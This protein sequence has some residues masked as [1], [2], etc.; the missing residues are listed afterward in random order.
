MSETL[1]TGR[2]VDDGPP[3]LRGPGTWSV[4]W[5]GVRTLTVLELRQ[6]IRSARWVIVVGFWALTVGAL[7]SLIRWAAMTSQTERDSAGALMYGTVLLLVLSLAS[8]VSPALSATSV[9]GDRS[10]GVLAIM[11]STLLSPAE[12]ALGKLLAAWTSALV[13]FAVT[14]PFLF[15]AFLEGG[16]SGGRFVI[17]TV[18]TAFTLLVVCAVGLMF[19]ALTARTSTSAA[20]TYLTVAFLGVGLPLV[21]VLGLAIVRSDDTFRQ[22]Y[23]AYGSDE[24]QLELVTESRA[25]TEKTWWLL[26]PSPYVIVSD[27]APAR[28][29]LGD[30]LSI[31]RSAVREA[32]LGPP[33]DEDY[34]SESRDEDRA[35]ERDAQPAVWPLGVAVDGLVLVGSVVVTVRRLRSP[36]RALPRG[37]RVA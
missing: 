7:S 37:S 6:R 25:H 15:W 35:A 5:G 18:L 34:C 30:P 12:L 24:C 3:L 11:Q 14:L 28:H 32:R 36:S 23:R 2:P 22:Q 19:S 4:T 8:L 9:N 33:I 29:D 16:T 27:A 13:L 26:A 10:A 1:G 17:T 20:L 31:I 21:F